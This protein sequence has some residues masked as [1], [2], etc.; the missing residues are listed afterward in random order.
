[1]DGNFGDGS[2]AGSSGARSAAEVRASLHGSEIHLRFP[3]RRDLVAGARR[4]PGRRWDPGLRVWRIPDTPAAREAVRSEFGVVVEALATSNAALPTRP[5]PD[6]LIQR[7]DEEMR[8]RG[9]AARTRKAYLGHAR[10][11]LSEFGEPTDLAADL[12]RHILRKLAAGRMSRSYHNQLTSALRLFCSTVLGRRLEELPLARPRREHRLPAVLSQEEFR[13]FLAAVRNPKHVAILAVTY[14]AGLRVSEVVR[15][16]P[17]DLDRER[18]LIR[19]RRGKGGKDRYT[20]LSGTALTLVD[21]YLEGMSCGRWLFPGARPS[22]HITS[23]S[24]QKVT[25]AA[26]R[27]AGISKPLTP[28]ILR[29]ISPERYSQGVRLR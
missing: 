22:R 27:R 25:A 12:R 14:S 28:H 20:L 21:T 4:I 1:M 23:R 18:R 8:L 26:R 24:V 16:H 2:S 6:P 29:H 7:F 19:V 9:Y 10:R 15:L 5:H 3:F 11:F 13:R 17:E